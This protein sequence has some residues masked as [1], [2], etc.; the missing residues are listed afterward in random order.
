[1]KQNNIIFWLKKGIQFFTC[2]CLLRTEYCTLWIRQNMISFKAPFTGLDKCA[3]VLHLAWLYHLQK[4]ASG[5]KLVLSSFSLIFFRVHISGV[6]SIA[7]N[8]ITTNKFWLNIFCLQNKGLALNQA[9]AKGSESM[10]TF[11][12]S[13]QMNQSKQQIRKLI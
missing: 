12:F 5:S 4:N 8:I 10:F 11:F 7:G 13:S 9:R 2:I 6:S 1:M 3:Q